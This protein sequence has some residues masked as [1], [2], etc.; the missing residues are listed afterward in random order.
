[1]KVGR[2]RIHTLLAGFAA[3]ATGLVV[4]LF[5]IMI[6]QH[7]DW[8]ERSVRN[9]WAF[10]D[11][12]AQRGAL[13]DRFGR[14][15]AEDRPALS[16]LLH[17]RAFRRDHPL[18]CA[19]HGANLL[20]A[21][22]GTARERFG[23]VSAQNGPVAAL[24]HLLAMPFRWLLG[25]E[26]AS[27]ASR[28][29]RF[30]VATLIGVLEDGR[31]RDGY[32]WL[33]E[34]GDGI[35]GGLRLA[36][37]L[38]A[39]RSGA[40]R[41]ALRRRAAEFAALDDRLSGDAERVLQ[42]ELE[43]CRLWHIEDVEREHRL[44]LVQRV[45]AFETGVHLALLRER[46]PGFTLQAS[47]ERQR[48]T[49]PGRD[50]VGSLDTV[51]GIVGPY[52]REHVEQMQ[53]RVAD[54][55]GPEILAELVP[56]TP[57][58][59]EGFA[60]SLADAA[61]RQVQLHLVARGRRGR[62]GVEAAMDDT[63]AGAPGLRL[64]EKNRSADEQQLLRALRVLPGRD[65]RLALDVDLQGEVEAALDRN[66]A[67]MATAIALLAPAT[68][69]LLAFGGRP[70]RRD[71]KPVWVTAAC[72]WPTTGAIGSVA[73]SFVLL[74]QLDA[75]RH[76]RPSTPAETYRP[77]TRTGYQVPG[78]PRS[79]TCSGLH[80]VAARDPA[81]ALAH[82]CNFF[83]YQAAEGLGADGVAQA[84]RR[85]GLLPY[86]AD[87]DGP[88]FVRA[89]PGLGQLARPRGER[90]LLQLRAIGYGLNATVIHVA[91]AYAALATG[92]LP[93]LVLVPGAR[94]PA[95][96]PLDVHPDDLA[97]VRAGMA[98]CVES[99]SA[100]RLPS[101]RALGVRAKTGTAEISNRTGANNAWFAGYVGGD[102]PTLAF[103]AVAYAVPDQ[104]HGGD[105]A[106]VL[107]ADLLAAVQADDTLRQRYLDG[108]RA[109]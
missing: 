80:G 39:E 59:P 67:G 69:E 23:Y 15:I 47:V 20:D 9:R 90:Q 60:G 13:Q 18:G 44:R 70:L 91:R 8:L 53:E 34:A 56:R 42:A 109:R 95:P 85:V 29:L 38:G 89:V 62:N 12:P 88:R 28:D 22:R 30:Y 35:G 74:E 48:R 63:L 46:Q 73:K 64:V 17:Y 40:L 25:E 26:I 68:G 51:L 33:D 58:L 71:G 96:A 94:H 6:V 52:W 49:L 43:R 4:H 3:C 81:Y 16:V 10:R 41:A 1:M 37:A 14:V 83:Y 5:W 102:R 55:L 78:M 97:V 61:R 7:D 45:V 108:A 65:V 36:E 106:G 27:E 103:A 100:R 105:V 107:V 104:Q 77:C 84:F 72:R 75:R 82:S 93:P 92:V 76:G 98:A 24:D 2:T 32:R 79:L 86:S 99:G 11:V 57:D 66:P 19:V 87:E 101:L 21:T 31:R 50:D 54:Q